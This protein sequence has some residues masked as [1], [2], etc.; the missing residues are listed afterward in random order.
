MGNTSLTKRS[1]WFVR[2][3]TGWLMWAFQGLAVR[4]SPNGALRPAWKS[5]GDLLL[6]CFDR[7][8]AGEKAVYL[9]GSVRGEASEEARDGEKQRVLWEGSG[10]LVGVREG[11][12]VVEL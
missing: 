11:E 6:A 9:D 10:R 3:L 8:Y 4:I 7:G 2:L 5:A 12:T 1:P